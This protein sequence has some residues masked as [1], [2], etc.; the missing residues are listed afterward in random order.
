MLYVTCVLILLRKKRHG[1]LWHI[2]SS[3]ILFFLETISLSLGITD[4]IYHYFQD[5]DIA[6][7]FTLSQA[8]SATSSIIQAATEITALLCL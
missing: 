4:Y 1:Y 5:I 6:K 8:G 2:A 3:T 7:G